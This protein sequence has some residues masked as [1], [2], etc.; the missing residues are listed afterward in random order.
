MGAKPKS[1]QGASNGA[2][3]TKGKQ[4]DRV[5]V[6]SM[7]VYLSQDL[8]QSI[9]TCQR[10]GN[11][12][13]LLPGVEHEFHSDS[14]GHAY[15]GR[16]NLDAASAEFGTICTPYWQEGQART[17]KAR[18][19]AGG[20]GGGL[21]TPGATKSWFRSQK[22]EDDMLLMC[23]SGKAVNCVAPNSSTRAPTPARPSG[24]KVP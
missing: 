13:P 9:L 23:R 20:V 17:A 11:A 24:Q 8:A 19:R 2:R 3:L 1:R 16:H 12:V 7:L 15:G 10:C 21:G 18:C 4:L 5:W 22:L 6:V 14:V